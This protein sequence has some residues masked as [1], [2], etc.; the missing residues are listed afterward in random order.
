M[1]LRNTHNR[2]G[3]VTIALHWVVALL[4]IGLFILGLYMTGLGYYDP[5]YVAAPNLHRSVGVILLLL[6]VLRLLWRL[7]NPAPEPVGDDPRILRRLAGSVH[8]LL[9]LLLFAIA[10]SGYLISTADGRGIEVFGW[11][12]LPALIPAF[13]NMEDVAGEIHYLL[14][15]T[16]M[17]LVVLHS[18][19]ALKHHF[20]DRDPTL[21]R[22][23]GIRRGH[24][25]M[26]THIN[27]SRSYP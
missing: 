9:Y 15:V 3:L 13:D 10:I 18:L 8:V 20:L 2:Y 26:T 24:A 22:M 16:M 14:A 11:F 7:L 12:T 6:L 5:W 21:T 25:N 27:P 1:D 19:A 17:L 4:V 23:L